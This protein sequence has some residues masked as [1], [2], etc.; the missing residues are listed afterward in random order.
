[1]LAFRKT[2]VTS[3][4]RVPNKQGGENNWGGLEWFNITI[5]EGLEQSVFGEIE[6]CR[7]MCE[8]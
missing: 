6:N 5:I 2:P 1:M 4:S 3:Y 8:E 7:F